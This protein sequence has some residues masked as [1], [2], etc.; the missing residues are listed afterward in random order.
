MSD[1]LGPYS[2]LLK[3]FSNDVRRLYNTPLGPYCVGSTPN[4]RICAFIGRFDL[5]VGQAADTGTA[6][7]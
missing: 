7:L 4:I 6:A 5:W 2:V 3:N 1:E